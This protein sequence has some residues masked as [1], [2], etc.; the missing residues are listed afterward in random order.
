MKLSLLFILF[1]A[2]SFG[3]ESLFSYAYEAHPHLPAGILETVAWTRTRN[4]HLEPDVQESCSGLPKAFGIMGL[5]ENGKDYF[6]ENASLIEELSGISI[7]EQKTSPQKQVLAYASAF[8]SI[9]S[10]YITTSSEEYAIY[11]TLDALT[12]IPNYGSVNL[13]ARDA[14]IY[15]IFKFLNDSEFAN[16]QG[17][18]SHN[19]DLRNVFGFQN[20]QVLSAERVIM[21]ETGIQT[22]TGTNF[23]LSQAKSTQYGP[24]IWSAAPTCNYSS[25][26]GTAVTAITIHTIQGSYAG[27]ISWSQNCASNVSF[28]YV[29]R[30]SDG[31]VTQMVLEENKAWH[32]GS[33]NPYTIGYEHEGYIDNPSWYTTAMYNSSADLSRDIINS[34]YGIPALRTYF[35]TGL[36]P[37]GACTKIKGHQHFPSQT[38]T[39][40]GIN[41]NWE[42]Y[43]RL[44]NNSTP[45]I[46]ITSPNDNFFDSG[47]SSTN[48]SDDERIIWTISPPNVLDITL[49]F[50]SFS[51]ENNYDYLY[52]Y[53]GSTID[54]P[55]VGQYT[56]TNTPGT[57]T[58][59]GGSLTIEFRSDCAT[60]S[61]GWA[62]SFTST[63]NINEQ[64]VTTI[65]NTG[66][67]RTEDFNIPITDADVE[68]NV[69]TKFYVLADKT[70]DA[71]G[72][73]ANT[74]G[75]FVYEEFEDNATNWTTQTGVFSL[76][77]NSFTQTD[78]S[79]ANTNAFLLVNQGATSDYL[80]EWDQTVTSSGVNQRS[81]LHFMCS[82]PTLTNRGNSYFIFLRETDNQVHIYSV[83]N[84]VFTLQSN[85]PYAL[86]IGSTYNIKTM[87][88]PTTG[89]IKV[90]INNVFVSSWQDLTPLTSGMGISLRTGNCET[91]YD[92]IKV[93]KSRTSLATA[94]V[95]PNSNFRYESLG[96]VATAKVEA[97]S[98]D[99]TNLWSEL[100]TSFYLI[101][102][103]IPTFNHVSDGSAADIDTSYSTTIFGNWEMTDLHSGIASYEYAIGTTPAGTDVLNWTNSGGATVGIQPLVNPVYNQLY[104]YSV[105]SKNG[106][107][108]SSNEFTSDGQLLIDTVSDLSLLSIGST[109]TNIKVF[110]N[111]SIDEIVFNQFKTPFLAQLTDMNGKIILQKRI[112]LEDNKMNLSSVSKGLYHLILSSDKT[113]I[114]KEIIKN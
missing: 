55:L 11:Y 20:L 67:W 87:Y 41:W 112:H 75:G 110:P 24:A 97:L 37:I 86:E 77:N 23:T 85:V 60:N 76:N 71:N 47:G 25:R 34:D 82:D 2:L 7:Q 93:F 42:L 6:I 52:I 40:P 78:V 99:A 103:S 26:S 54:A 102:L 53:D 19:Y 64:P 81:G 1:A 45:T 5:F 109:L 46:T 32:V 94:T 4:T 91:T 65:T 70:T 14:Q 12:E 9:F 106:A 88:S 36:S 48:Y 68:T 79:L 43:Y 13:Y 73:Q 105:R 96:A 89:W 108:L 8:N 66:A 29:I 61:P 74:A 21:S 33:E 84:D 39:D 62:A 56:G 101:D 28:H 100:V 72:W 83:D 10:N 27:A 44:I 18:I 35:G 16:N 107:G 92:N 104:Y 80:Y 15:E 30:S 57:V 3:Q 90:Y 69:D 63:S 22:E 113:F 95:G 111:P 51:L 50:S 17:F 38:H 31:Q 114:V 58:S 59:T 98:K 49:N